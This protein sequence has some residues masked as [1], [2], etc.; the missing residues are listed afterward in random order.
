MTPIQERYRAKRI[1]ERTP[2]NGSVQLRLSDRVVELGAQEYDWYVKV[3]D[4]L[5]SV[6]GV[7]DLS[8]DLAMDEAKVPRF[9]EAL[10]SAGLLYRTAG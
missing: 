9:V 3:A 4:W 1:Y 10:E 6:R 7:A 5:P 8:R 2:Q